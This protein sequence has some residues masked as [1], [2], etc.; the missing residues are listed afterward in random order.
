VVLG[1]D[2][3]VRKLCFCTDQRDANNKMLLED[4]RLTQN[5]IDPTVS[6]TD[7]HGGGRTGH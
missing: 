1:D 7:P 4:L 3:G 2:D 6:K 5:K